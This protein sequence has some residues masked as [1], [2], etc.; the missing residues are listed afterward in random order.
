MIKLTAFL[1]AAGLALG[2]V[3]ADARPAPVMAVRSPSPTPAIAPPSSMGMVLRKA[4]LHVSLPDTVLARI[5]L[6][7]TQKAD[8]SLR[9]FFQAAAQ[10]Q[11][12][13]DRLTPPVRAQVLDL[14]LQKKLLSARVSRE[15]RHWSREDSTSFQAAQDNLVMRAALDSAEAELGFRIA[16]RGDTVPERAELDVM[17]RDSAL[18]ALRPAYDE[19]SIA[20]LAKAFADRPAPD[21]AAGMEEQV[22]ART[23][24]PRVAARDSLR[25]LVHSSVGDITEGDLLAKLGLLSPA[26]RPEVRTESDI[27]GLVDNMVFERLLRAH[28]EK[29]GLARRKDVRAQLERRAE[30]LDAQA[31]IRHAAYDPV[32]LDSATV[33]R[34]FEKH[35]KWFA[36]WGGAEVVLG[37]FEKRAE[38]AAFAKRVAVKAYADSIAPLR[39]AEGRA[40]SIGFTEDSDTLLYSR[41]RRAGV[42]GVVGPD[43]IEGG[44][45]V[46]RVSALTPRRPR[47]FEEAYD[48]AAND[49]YQR[50]GDRRVRA[51]M[52]Q[53]GAS[54]LVQ[55]NEPL[56]AQ[57]TPPGGRGPAAAGARRAP[58]PTRPQGGKR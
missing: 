33:R 30:L 55:V 28:A 18:A 54:A 29:Q 57:L 56:L 42:G 5:F 13:P 37:L 27:R 46:L 51:L 20:Q 11:V 1:A 58:A 3:H 14:L 31:Y 49:W 4:D 7:N 26:Y 34:H 25:L 48:I 47:T 52:Q 53:M 39:T 40:W 2:A 9:D 12:T 10:L 41:V 38:A 6:S 16:S 50:D 24:L 44:F 21:S 22:R 36:T 15:G 45:R 8:V 17:V 35:P 32:P 43:E 23:A 19:A